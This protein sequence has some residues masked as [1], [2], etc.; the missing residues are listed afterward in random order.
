MK[1]RLIS[2]T[3]GFAIM[4]LLVTGFF[5]L[6]E[7]QQAMDGSKAELLVAVNEIEQLA[8]A[9][10]GVGLTEKIVELTQYIR[11][12]NG[13]SGE[14]GRL[15]IL[16]GI[17]LLFL[18]CVFTY[19]YFAIL[20]PFDKLKGFAEKIAQGDFDIALRYERSNYFGA[21]T[22]AFDSMRREITKARSCEKEAIENNKTVIATLSHDIKTPISSIRAYAEGLEANMDSTPQKRERYLSVIMKK[23]DEVSRLTNDLFLHS[24][25]DLEKL[26]ITPRELEL[27]GFLKEAVEELGAEQN[28]IHFTVPTFTLRVSA[29]E[30]RLLQIVENLVNN[31]RK[32]AKT[33]IDIFCIQ[34]EDGASIH[35]QDYGGGIPDEDMPFIFEKFYRGKNC[36]GEQGSGLGLYIVKYLTEQMQGK[37]LLHNHEG[38]LEAIITLPTLAKHL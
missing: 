29:D 21:F 9:G 22:W 20:R 32:Y 19:V 31:A 4:L 14:Y 27:C 18:L 25:A 36:N 35:I 7:R 1:Q 37:I 2:V 16:C 12:L 23:C 15:L 28:D 3:A 10:E 6:M 30:N 33:D 11:G 26:K 5:L 8:K 38:G 17:C 13:V 24:L 34:D